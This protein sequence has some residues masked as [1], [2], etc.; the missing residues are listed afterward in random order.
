MAGRMTRRRAV[1]GLLAAG[2]A[3]LMGA[4]GASAVR[5]AS[6]A[7][8]YRELAEGTA[9]QAGGGGEGGAPRR[10]W[11]ALRAQFPAVA[12]WVRVEGT[13]IDLPV[14]GASSEADE[15]WFLRHDLWGRESLSGTPFTDRRCGGADARNVVVYGH[16]MTYSDAMF[17][18]LQRA[19]EQDAFDALGGMAWETPAADAALSPLFA[20]RVEETWPDIQTF[21]FADGGAFREWLAGMAAQAAAVSP[22]AG[23]LLLAAERCVALVTCASDWAGQPWR[24][25]CVWCA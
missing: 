22:Q 1:A 6:V 7:G 15:G 8:A 16:H 23:P 9:P 10:D 5:E 21:G 12:A 14:A 11:A 13:P 3:A 19:Y 2:G 25:V 17:S 20:V 18:C 4:V 24:T